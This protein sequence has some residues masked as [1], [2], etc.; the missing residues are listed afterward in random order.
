MLLQ[1]TVC[2]CEIFH[3]H[4]MGSPYRS[5]EYLIHSETQSAA[6][7]NN[8]V[9]TN[10]RSQLNNC[11]FQ[12]R[13]ENWNVTMYDKLYLSI[14]FSIYKEITHVQLIGQIYNQTTTDVRE[15]CKSVLFSKK[16]R[17]SRFNLL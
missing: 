4:T 17:G 15:L 11:I 2:Q 6:K 13:G 7:K 16:K 3:T 8:N 1:G 14:I 5:L 12:K 10:T 9:C